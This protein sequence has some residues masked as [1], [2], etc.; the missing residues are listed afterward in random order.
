[1]LHDARKMCSLQSLPSFLSQA[2]V[3]CPFSAPQELSWTLERACFIA[4]RCQ[5]SSRVNPV[6][7]FGHVASYRLS[8]LMLG[9]V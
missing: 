5:E 9:P 4:Y 1:M 7:L 2:P 8:T 3:L 6:Y